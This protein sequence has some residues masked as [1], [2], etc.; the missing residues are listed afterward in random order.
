MHYV[1][2]YVDYYIV[3]CILL[4]HFSEV[5]FIAGLLKNAEFSTG[6]KEISGTQGGGAELRSE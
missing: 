6:R 4:S 3:Q 1:C 5:C 2:M